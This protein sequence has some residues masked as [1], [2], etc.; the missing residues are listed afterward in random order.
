MSAGTIWIFKV[1]GGIA[2]LIALLAIAETLIR[3][4]KRRTL[5]EKFDIDPASLGDTHTTFGNPLGGGDIERANA[6]MRRQAY[7]ARRAEN[8]TDKGRDDERT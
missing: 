8:R 3:K 1:L 6:Y 4:P 5:A 7:G 2:V